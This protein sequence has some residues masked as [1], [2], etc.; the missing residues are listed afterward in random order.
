MANLPDPVVYNRKNEQMALPHYVTVDIRFRFSMGAITLID[1]RAGMYLHLVEFPNKDEEKESEWYFIVDE[2]KTGIK[3]CTEGNHICAHAVNICRL[4]KLKTK[5]I[6]AGSISFKILK[7]KVEYK[8]KKLWKIDLKSA[9][10][11]KR[12]Y[13]YKDR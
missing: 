4:F 5:H 10:K 9:F 3:L 11:T 8:G 12:N 7:T 2:D 13:G 1:M 6:S